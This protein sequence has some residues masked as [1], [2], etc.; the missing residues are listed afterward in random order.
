MRKRPASSR[1]SCAGA[2]SSAAVFP[3]VPSQARA[4][5]AE[6]LT[7]QLAPLAKQRL[8]PMFPLGTDFDADEQRLVPA[9]QWLKRNSQTWKG[10]LSLA[11]ALGSVP[12]TPDEERALARMRFDAPRNFQERMMRRLVALALRETR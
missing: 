9:L 1:T 7:A 3:S 2:R 5:T 8:L 12:S 11:A 4:N 6:R 10:K